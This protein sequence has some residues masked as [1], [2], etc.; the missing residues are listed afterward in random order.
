MKRIIAHILP[1][2][3][4][5]AFSLPA[6]ASQYGDMRREAGTYRPAFVGQSLSGAKATGRP[7]SFAP[8]KE[9]AVKA[10]DEAMQAIADVSKKK[11]PL[12]V[13]ALLKESTTP[14][15]QAELER[16]NKEIE[17]GGTP[18]ALPGTVTLNRLLAS[19]IVF[20]PAVQ[21][22]EDN[23]RAAANRYDQVVFLDQVLLQYLGFTESINTKTSSKKNRR[24]VQM[25]YPFPGMVSLKG[26]AVDKDVEI[27]RVAFEKVVRDVLAEV[28]VKY[29]NVLYL[30]AALEITRRDLSLAKDI[31]KVALRLYET[32][33]AEYSNV[34][35][36]SMRIDKLAT[37]EDTFEWK[38]N[39][40]ITA[41]RE[42]IGLPG[43]LKP[44]S[45]AETGPADVPGLRALQALAQSRS[46]ELRSMQ[47]MIERMDIMIEMGGRKLFPDYSLGFSYFQNREVLS[48]GTQGKAAAFMTR[49]MGP[50]AMPDYA[51]E[52]AYLREVKDKRNSLA[53]KL[54]DMRNRTNSMVEKFF[55]NY[56]ASRNTAATYKK[57]II[58]KAHNAYK[59]TLGDY[60][61]G[62]GSFIDLLDAHRVLLDQEL[63]F[64]GARRKARTNLALLEKTVGGKIAVEKGADSQ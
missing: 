12:S 46:Q 31:D 43:E 23:L 35:K 8:D 62:D 42:V 61:S 59:A 29:A 50:G 25:N 53:Q 45:F 30:D 16:I 49:S 56:S 15:I 33:M 44:G 27:A 63:A 5:A 55:A 21:A 39:A 36:I 18:G 28:K 11:T 14:E 6:A 9:N 24:M 13:A 60:T 3:L 37:M 26:D 1:I 19:A 2:I 38:R 52:N 57:S 40:A 64:E 58:R 41:L 47:L 54:E 48:L 20:S 4:I 32:G 34:V 17:N 10:F 51:D 7:A 22:A